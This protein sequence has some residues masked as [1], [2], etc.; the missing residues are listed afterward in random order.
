MNLLKAWNAKLE[1]GIFL[2]VYKPVQ[3]VWS[4]LV[5]LKQMFGPFYFA[6]A[7]VEIALKVIN[8]IGGNCVKK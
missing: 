3:A 5:Q 8:R 4:F 6:T 2:V 1:A 7:L